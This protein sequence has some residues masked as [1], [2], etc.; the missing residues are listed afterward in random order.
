MTAT[1]RAAL[2]VATTVTALVEGATAG[3]AASTATATAVATTATVHALGPARPGLA[4]TIVPTATTA[5]AAVILVA[6]AGGVSMA[7]AVGAVAIPL[8]VAVVT[9]VGVDR[10]VVG[11]LAATVT[12]ATGMIAASDGCGG[13]DEDAEHR[14]QACSGSH[15][16]ASN[17]KR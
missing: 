3:A 16:P 1:E 15:C 7:A 13:D 17:S 4:P 14:K 6:G 2:A 12:R 9:T 11:S 10:G 5:D 8:A